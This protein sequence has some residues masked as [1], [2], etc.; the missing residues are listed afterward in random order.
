MY[1][2]SKDSM[3]NPV[4]SIKYQNKKCLYVYEG[5]LK[6]DWVRNVDLKNIKAMCIFDGD[7]DVDYDDIVKILD[8]NGNE[9]TTEVFKI[10]DI[11]KPR[12]L[13]TGRVDHTK[14]MLA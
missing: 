9:T 14:V 8:S 2:I 3:N 10:V 5:K 7:L 4:S 12:N 13:H 11:E 6:R 1:S